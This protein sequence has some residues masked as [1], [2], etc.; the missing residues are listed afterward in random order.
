MSLPAERAVTELQGKNFA[1]IIGAEDKASQRPVKVGKQVGDQLLILEGLKSGDR[2]IVA[3]HQK[4]REGAVVKP[5]TAQETA[6]FTQAAKD[7]ATAKEGEGKQ[8]KK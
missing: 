6:Q 8:N 1:W 3:G 5:M 7:S 2:V 4:V